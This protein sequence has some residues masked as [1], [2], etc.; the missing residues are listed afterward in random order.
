MAVNPRS[1]PYEKNEKMENAKPK[2]NKYPSWHL[3]MVYLKK[4]HGSSR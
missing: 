1:P 4:N 2:N 3:A